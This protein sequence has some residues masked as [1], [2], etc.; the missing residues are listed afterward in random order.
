MIYFFSFTEAILAFEQIKSGVSTSDI[1]G[2]DSSI[3][4]GRI[5][6]G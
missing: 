4:F 1:T 6:V 2:A 3:G 5:K